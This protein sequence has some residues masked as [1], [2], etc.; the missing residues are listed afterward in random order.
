MMLRSYR[1]FTFF[2]NT[3][4]CV[5]TLKCRYF[6]FDIMTGKLEKA[7]CFLQ[8]LLKTEDIY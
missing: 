7:C 3:F 1:L 8:N 6:S 2:L 5:G 4:L